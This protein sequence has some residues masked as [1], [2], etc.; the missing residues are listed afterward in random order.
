MPAYHWN[1]A[2]YAQAS[3]VQ[4]QWARELIAKL[5]WQGTER[6]LDIGCGDGKVTA[7]IAAALPRGT[8]VGVDNSPA[9]IALAEASYPRAT[10]ANLSFQLAE[11]ANLPFSAEFEVVFSNATLHWVLDH[12]PV[13]RGVQRSLRPGGTMLLQMGGRGNALGVIAAVE[14]VCAD[15]AWRSYFD[16]MRFPYGFYGPEEYR[17]W[18]AEAGLTA[19]RV[20]LI[21]KD[22]RHAG[23]AGLE[24]WFR[25][26]WLPYT[27]RVPEALRPDFIAQVMDAYLEKNPPDTAGE[28]HV[29][30]TRLE[31][32]ASR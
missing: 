11:A 31:V 2:D 4:Q 3:T 8:V 15:P 12:A 25:T 30:M 6:V 19:R 17:G 28:V 23:R 26:T 10:W 29:Q 1:A 21:P 27:Q 18:L 24:G 9:M 20:E 22:M 14:Q 7:E 13:L 32:E 16:G 5:H